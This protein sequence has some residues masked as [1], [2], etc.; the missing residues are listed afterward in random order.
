M[1]NT[2]YAEL[3]EHL[4]GVLKTAKRLGLNVQPNGGYS[5][6]YDINNLPPYPV[7][8][9]GALSIVEGHGARCRLGLTFDETES[10]EA[11]FNGSFPE[12]KNKKKKKRRNF[13]PDMELMK[14]GVELA[15]TL[16]KPLRRL[17]HYQ[18]N[19][20]DGPEMV[21]LPVG[22]DAPMPAPVS[23]ATTI[24]PL[25]P[26]GGQLS[27]GSNAG[28]QYSNTGVTTTSTTAI[29]PAGGM[30]TSDTANQDMPAFNDE[31][32]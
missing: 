8:L 29:F 19:W 2:K 1:E 9:F 16:H 15:L 14:I 7:G 10:L 5:M 22:Q 27:F 24:A 20:D 30:Y 26:V 18:G 11:G 17:N 3:K 6:G 32:E 28:W 12:Q 31:E 4:K 13:K 21:F 23:V 25:V